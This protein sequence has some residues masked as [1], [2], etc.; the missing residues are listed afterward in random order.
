MEEVNLTPGLG[1]TGLL[2]TDAL[3]LYTDNQYL[4]AF[5]AAM[6]GGDAGALDALEHIV[7][8]IR[9]AMAQLV[10]TCQEWLDEGKYDA[11]IWHGGKIASL[12][13]VIGDDAHAALTYGM[14][15]D[16]YWNYYKST[17]RTDITL[18]LRLDGTGRYFPVGESNIVASSASTYG[19]AISKAAHH[20]EVRSLLPRWHNNRGLALQAVD[21]IDEAIK[22]FRIAAQLKPSPEANL[23]TRISLASALV[24]WGE[25]RLAA[26]EY[27]TICADLDRKVERDN[28]LSD[29][30]VLTATLLAWATVLLDRGKPAE[31]EPL[32]ERAKRMVPDDDLDHRIGGLFITAYRL[33]GRQGEAAQAFRDF[34]SRS[35]E[36]AYRQVDFDHFYEGYG[37]ALRR[38]LD[39]TNIA[40]RHFATGRRAE[41]YQHWD[42]ARQRYGLAADLAHYA[43]DRLLNLWSRACIADTLA[44]EQQVQAAWEECRRVHD[45][46]LDAGLAS[47]LAMTSM[48]MASLLAAGLDEGGALSAMTKA[49]EGMAYSYVHH[50]LAPKSFLPADHP[51]RFFPTA[52]GG[53]Q[54]LVARVALEHSAYDL[55]EQYYR[56]AIAVSQ[57]GNNRSN[58]E[59][60][61]KVG[62]LTCL[63]AQPDR[64]AEIET[65][66]QELRAAAAD[67]DT[68]LLLRL[69]IYRALGTR[70]TDSA[71]S[72]ADLQT[73]AA[74][75]EELRGYRQPGAARSDLDREYAVYPRLLWRQHRMGAPA[76]EAFATLQAMRARRLMETL[77]AATGED[78]PYSPITVDEIRDRLA[79]QP[80]LTT[81][82][83]IAVTETGLRAYLVDREGL[84]TIDAA[85]DTTP[86]GRGQWDDVLTT[87]SSPRRAQWGGDVRERAA[88]V[89]T[90][91][92]HSPLL[93][94][95]AAAITQ[96]LPSDSTVLLAVDDVL[97]NLPLHAIP[98]GD[99]AWGDLVSIGRIAAAGA[100]RFT[101]AARGSSGRSIIAGDSNNDLPGA[102]RECGA[103]ARMLGTEPLLGDACTVDAVRA[104]LTASPN[105]RLDVVHLAVH[106]RADVKRGGR[107]SLLF[108]G[109]RP[110]WVP[111]ED[112]SALPWQAQLIVFSGCSTAVGGPRNGHGLYGVAQAAAEAG[113]TTVIASLW[114]V[115]DTSAADFMTAFYTDLSHRRG[116]GLIDL[117][118]PMDYARKQLREQLVNNCRIP[119]ARD[120][121]ELI[122]GGEDL[123]VSIQGDAE[124][125]AIMHWAPFVIIG[126]PTLVL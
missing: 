100:L 117:R 61:R 107:S 62:L 55:A 84:R 14:V 8:E 90:L 123:E 102:E 81:F 74:L 12:A 54:A 80:R 82:V 112:L 109:T 79:Q 73:A 15:A 98:V 64:Q 43:G 69:V 27:E 118:E 96:Q 53:L 77:T 75:L 60:N 18:M 56:D 13:R 105:T 110:S 31:V 93:A 20:P 50:L 86:L 42:L 21:R 121:R 58:S 113:A 6:T 99:S 30:L 25:Y 45:E 103:V 2:V 32:L 89:A 34:W 4:D 78:A 9:D 104:A 57:Y 91:V 5:V 126:E 111:F 7:A 120:G 19:L 38:V 71:Q 22:Q 52:I 39:S 3:D 115:D 10:S 41:Y 23:D 88:E 116:Q 59:L 72:L 17:G 101:P 24:D 94:E 33:A 26:R 29:R 11:V 48:T 97:G 124:L 65:L 46:A 85:G 1:D 66:T 119:V 47:P 95:T 28:K 36:H 40:W 122:L 125:A 83:D 51:E 106:G 108:A 67:P 37:R 49:A 114:P 92:A 63:H 76:E 68:T 70:T 35:L 87:A 16:A 44:S